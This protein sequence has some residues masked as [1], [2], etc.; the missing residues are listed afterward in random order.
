MTFKIAHLSDLHL[1]YRSS[2][3]TTES[4]I[5][6]REMDGYLS[7]A[8]CVNEIINEN[9]DAAIVAGDVFHIPNPSIRAIIFAQK[10]F[11]KLADAGVKVYILAGNHD[12]LDVVGDIAAS[13]VLDDSFR[14]IYSGAEPYVHYE[15]TDGI[16]LH[17]CSHHLYSLQSE[18]M[19]Q[20]KPIEGELNILS[21]HGSV[22]D[23]HLKEK[24]HTDQSPREVVIPKQI[25]TDKNWSYTFLGHIHERGFV[26]SKDKKN[27]SLKKRIYYN[28]SL[29]RRGFSDKEVPLGRGWTLWEID[30]N[31]K[32][33]M[34]PKL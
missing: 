4:G 33:T 16:N 29:I 20:I 28:G 30:E 34:T 8:T 2:R 31:G 21:T 1:Q 27:D 23:P 15:I 22:I 14:G 26:G 10:Q 9:C 7:F 11:R 3:L 18:T 25:L 6:L 5:N 32:F 12:S 17:M 24:L 19:S 13:K